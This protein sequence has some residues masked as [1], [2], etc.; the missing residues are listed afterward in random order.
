MV[1]RRRSAKFLA[2][3]II[4]DEP[5]LFVMKAGKS[6]VVCLAIGDS[7]LEGFDYVSATVTERNWYR[8]LDGY[9][10]LRYLFT[11]PFQR[12]LFKFASNDWQDDQ[13]L[14]TPHDGGLPEEALPSKGL[15]SR[16]HTEPFKVDEK[17]NGHEQLFI[18]GEW[19]LDEFGKFY[20]KYADIYSLT[21]VL[22]NADDASIA[23]V[24]KGRAASALSKKP[25]AGGSSYLHVF[26]ELSSCIPRQQ[27]LGLDGIVYNSPGDVRI[28]GDAAKLAKV[29]QLVSNFVINRSDLRDRHKELRDYLARNKFLSMSAASYGAENEHDS[30]ISSLNQALALK[31]EFDEFET[32]KTLCGNNV[33]VTAKVTLALFRRLESAAAFFSEGRMAFERED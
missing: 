19:Q 32:L 27:K 14:M 4:F 33:L 10:D 1:I 13:V 5:Q 22:G 25:Y 9:V 24:Y 15:F 8:Y 21:A 20:Q 23:Q 12:R 11:Y 30:M 3:L 7:A 2:N 16:A 6:T 31:L 29:E 28:W 17:P 18:D 26:D